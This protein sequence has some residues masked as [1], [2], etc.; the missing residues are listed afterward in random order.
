VR[1]FFPLQQQPYE[2]KKCHQIERMDAG[3][4][5]GIDHG[6]HAMVVEQIKQ[7]IGQR[8]LIALETRGQKIEGQAVDKRAVAEIVVIGDEIEVQILPAD[9]GTRDRCNDAEERNQK[10]GAAAPGLIG[11]PAGNHDD[12][13][14]RSRS[15]RDEAMIWSA[16]R[17]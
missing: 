17:T 1:V 3:V 13:S 16:N 5:R 7:R 12:R 4:E 2:K 6:R 11:I 15:S 9:Q 10:K 14:R 8:R